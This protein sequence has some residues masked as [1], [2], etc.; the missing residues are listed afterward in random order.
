[1]TLDALPPA[2]DGGARLAFE[3]PVV[4][5]DVLVGEP[6]VLGDLVDQVVALALDV[7]RRVARI[8]D[9]ES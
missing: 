5:L 3:A 7:G 6:E 2:L 9:D 1:M 4:L 8:L